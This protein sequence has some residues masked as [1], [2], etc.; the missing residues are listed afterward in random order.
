MTCDEKCER[1]PYRSRRSH[2]GACHRTFSVISNFDLHRRGGRCVDP[3]AVGLSEKAGIW[4][5]WNSG[6]DNKWWNDR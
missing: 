6:S 3:A 2:C 4:A 1:L 5:R